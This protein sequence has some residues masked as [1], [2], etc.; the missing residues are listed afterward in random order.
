VETIGTDGATSQVVPYIIGMAHSL[1]LAIVAEGVETQA[2]A[3]FL[4]E[5]GV[6]YAQG[7]LFSKAL[8]IAKLREGLH[9]QKAPAQSPN[10][11][12]WIR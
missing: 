12:A 2:Q 11:L 8:P 3:D 1:E 10:E 5:R 7:W 6:Q 9:A 4:N